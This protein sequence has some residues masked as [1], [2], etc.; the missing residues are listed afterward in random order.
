SN[1]A[2]L[3]RRWLTESRRGRL[4]PAGKGRKHA[5]VA[6]LLVLGLLP[7]TARADA[8]SEGR[9]FY[10]EAME[11]AGDATGRKNAFA[12]A[13]VALGE[14]VRQHPDRPELLADW[15][16]AALGAGDVATATLA[17]RRALALDGRNAR[18]RHNLEWLRGKQPDALRPIASAG[19]TDTLLFFHQWPR[20]QRLLVGACAFA[21]A[22][23]LLVP[24]T[25][26]RR[27]GIAAIAVL[28]LAVWIAMVVSVVAEDRNR[29]DAVVMDGVVIRAADSAG[30]PA[31]LGQPLP[32]GAEVTILE[33]R[34]AWTRIRIASGASG[35][36]P[37]GA[38][39]PVL[40]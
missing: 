12:R 23:L 18:A 11:L 37:A 14:A 8:L 3:M 40:R 28:P 4:T 17:Y 38:V 30:A 21:I 33:R 15:G 26:R 13:A 19:A 36:V 6:S 1:A 2:G 31:T 35:W 5:A 22:I 20:S 7:S 29:D 34:D 10:Q 32:R 9:A 24:W 25:A 27:R 39:E 16:N